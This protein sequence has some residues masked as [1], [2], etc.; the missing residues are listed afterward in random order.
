MIWAQ[1]SPELRWRVCA[2]LLFAAILAIGEACIRLYEDSARAEAHTDA[3]VALGQAQARVE[4]ELG[5][6]LYLSSGL[7]AYFTLNA[8]RLDAGEVTELFALLY[9]D[10]EH[11]RNFGLAIGYVLT[12]V[13]PEAGNSTAVGLDYR[14]QPRQ[15]SSGPH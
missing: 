15:S 8:D 6:L 5:S 4:S 11:V 3:A 9:A 7:S 14:K 13:Y 1:C 2:A 10:T 12:H